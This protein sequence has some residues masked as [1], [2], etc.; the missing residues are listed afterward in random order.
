MRDNLF[1]VAAARAASIP[2]R[3]SRRRA[4]T[5][6]KKVLILKPCCL[7]QVM[8]TTPLLAVLSE[9]YPA[10]QFDWAIS[11]W[12][13]PAVA[14]NRRI[15]E[16]IGTGDVGL[17]GASWAAVRRLIARLRP[18][19][20]DTCVIPSRSS[21]L[22]LI[23][24]RAGIPQRIGLDQNG[25]GFAHTTRVRPLGGRHE[26]EVYLSLAHALHI[27][28]RLVARA[29]RMEFYPP[30]RDRTE[31]TARLVEE[32]DWLGREPLVVI[33][34]GGGRNPIADEAL[35]QWPAE[36]FALLANHL[37]RRHGARVVLVGAAADRPLAE[38]VAGMM[39]EPAVNLAGQISLGGLGALCE[40]ADLYV[41]NDAG[42]THVASAIGCPTLAIFGPSEPAVSGPYGALERVRALWRERDFEPFSWERGVTVAETAVV[43]DELLAQARRRA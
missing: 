43:A 6:P 39:S 2:F 10:A 33:H 41:G 13:R 34:P 22:A 37:V 31:M 26:A 29:G 7:S 9:A 20:Y 4:F 23:A 27:D 8:L 28:P 18:E 21:L 42:P 16:L 32:V 1:T 36:R 38:A 25:R 30:D 14:G 24:W 12:A 11:D 17:G 3:L 40:L 19:A 5:T 35:K 15:T